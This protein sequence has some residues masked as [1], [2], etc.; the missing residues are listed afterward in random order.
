MAG[1]SANDHGKKGNRER[2]WDWGLILALVASLALIYGRHKSSKIDKTR[3]KREKEEAMIMVDGHGE[4]G[5]QFIKNFLRF[6]SSLMAPGVLFLLDLVRKKTPI[7][8][9]HQE[10]SYLFLFFLL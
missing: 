7:R 8:S 9:S 6:H 2:R 3:R 1:N 5:V 4:E 10:S